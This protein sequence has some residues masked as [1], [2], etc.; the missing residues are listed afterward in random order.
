MSDYF[1]GAELERH[2]KMLWSRAKAGTK[3]NAQEVNAKNED[4]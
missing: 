1:L 4:C 3:A 2:T